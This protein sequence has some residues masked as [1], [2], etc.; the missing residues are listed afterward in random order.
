LNRYFLHSAELRFSHPSTGKVM[1]FRSPLPPE[2]QKLLNQLQA[3][4]GFT[5]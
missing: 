4:T 2:L 5:G 1:S 3:Q